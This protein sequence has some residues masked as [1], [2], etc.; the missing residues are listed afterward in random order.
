MSTPIL[1]NI[2]VD[3][4]TAINEITTG[5]GYNQDLVAYRSKRSDYKDFTPSDLTALVT[6][7]E[8]ELVEGVVGAKTWEQPFTIMVIVLDSDTAGT[9]IDTRNNQVACDIEKKLMVDPTRGG[10]AID[11]TILP[12]VR[13]ND[14]KGFTGV[15]V[16]ALVQYRTLINNP[17]TKA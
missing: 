15:A 10:N 6:Q 12:P 8:P 4:E 9:A 5:N 7:M 14:G 16:T 11:T 17:Y 1:E 3:I 2:A 13:F